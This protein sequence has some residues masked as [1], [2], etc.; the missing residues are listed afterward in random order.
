MFYHYYFLHKC[1]KH[2]VSSCSISVWL[3]RGAWSDLSSDTWHSWLKLFF[4]FFF[5]FLSSGPLY[6]CRDST[7]KWA[8]T[9]FFPFHLCLLTMIILSCGM[10]FYWTIHSVKFVGSWK[11]PFVPAGDVARHTPVEGCAVHA[12]VEMAVGWS[13]IAALVGWLQCGGSI[14]VAAALVAWSYG[15]GSRTGCLAVCGGCLVTGGRLVVER[16][17]WSGGVRRL[18]QLPSVWGMTAGESRR[19][20]AWWVGHD[21]RRAEAAIPGAVM[22]RCLWWPVALDQAYWLTGWCGRWVAWMVTECHWLSLMSLSWNCG[23]LY[24]AWWVELRLSVAIVSADWLV[25]VMFHNELGSKCCIN[26]SGG[27]NVIG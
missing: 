24:P 18:S 8:M 13:C 2:V 15:C 5:F 20:I 14:V 27:S 17:R 26:M 6:K 11:G 21:R 4:S 19:S 23:F 10:L 22:C 7:L 3:H 16:G 25:H 9:T 12:L 1:T